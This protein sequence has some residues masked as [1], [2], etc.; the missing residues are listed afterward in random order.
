MKLSKTLKTK[1]L[2]KIIIAFAIVFIPLVIN[3]LVDISLSKN[4]AISKFLFGSDN[5]VLSPS[6]K[7]IKPEDYSSSSNLNGI[8]VGNSLISGFTSNKLNYNIV[9]Q[10]KYDEIEISVDKQDEE[11]V[12]TGI[13]NVS[14][15]GEEQELQIAVT[16]KDG[17][18]TSIYTLNISYVVIEDKKEKTEFSYTGDYQ[19]YIVPYSGYYQIELWGAQGGSSSTVGGKGA[20]TSGTIYLKKDEKIYVYVGESG[21]N[22]QTATYNGGGYSGTLYNARSGGGA[23]DIRLVS[24]S[25]DEFE[26]LKSRIMVA[27]GGGGSTAGNYGCNG[28]AGGTLEGLAGA[29][30]GSGS[31]YTVA[32]GGKQ[33]SPG[34]P[35]KGMNG[36]T[37]EAA[38]F[39]YGG[40][41]VTSHGGGGRW[42]LLWW[43]PVAIIIVE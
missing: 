33:T 20:Y 34:T 18:S 12:V 10:E 35:G 9:Y 32:G 36:N 1:I 15:S 5:T 31:G 22:I 16:S 42:W 26:S 8:Y 4:N 30:G 43:W 38:G 11:Q 21:G 23:T 40:S 3:Y 27:A 41:G 14:L 37:A 13:G 2:N 17:T 24:G 28:G 6:D 19:E 39:G 29:K 7:E 25:W